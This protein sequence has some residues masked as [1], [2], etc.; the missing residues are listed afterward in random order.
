MPKGERS[1]IYDTRGFPDPVSYP[2]KDTF[3]M[4]GKDPNYKKIS[5]KQKYEFKDK[6]DQ[7]NPQSYLPRDR[8]AKKN[9]PIFSFGYRFEEDIR[10]RSPG[11]HV[12]PREDVEQFKMSRTADQWKRV[13]S[14]SFGNTQKLKR[15]DNGVPGTGEYETNLKNRKKSPSYTIGQ[16][17]RE[18]NS[19]QEANPGPVNKNPQLSLS[20]ASIHNAARASHLSL[21][22]RGGR[23]SSRTVNL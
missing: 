10:E 14:S 21:R 7:V 19:T 3:A 20:R 16:G 4:L 17:K 22:S 13:T 1:K 8:I 12:Y 23:N 2:P 11:P 9:L 18:Y 5:F 6:S 15:R